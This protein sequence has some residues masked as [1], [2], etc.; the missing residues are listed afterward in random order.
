MARSAPFH[1]SP[2][3]YRGEDGTAEVTIQ[4][5]G[6]GLFPGERLT[7]AV[8]VAAGASLVVRGQGATK[9]Y[10]SP[11]GEPAVSTTRL[12]VAAGGRLRWLPGE[13]IPFR[14]A[15][16]VQETI[17][18]VAV[19]G[20][21]AL[22]EL[23][24]PGRVAMGERDA[25]RRLELRLRVERAGRPLLIERARLEPAVR[26]LASPGRQGGFGCAGTL[27]LVGF[28]EAARGLGQGGPGEP[29]WWGSGGDDD[30]TLVRLL[31][32]SAQA[33]REVAEGLL[34]RVL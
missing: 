14:D 30:L 9:L 15:V 31:G 20:R 26:P 24:T 2:A 22:L 13:L 25:Y 12:E 3:I 32:P 7:A 17:A 29:V 19:G 16:L 11:S 18:D 28:G 8:T 33:V 4:A 1:P 6:P 27:V 34:G 10:P 21:L 23:L 5:V